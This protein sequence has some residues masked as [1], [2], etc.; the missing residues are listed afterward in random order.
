VNKDLGVILIDGGKDEESVEDYRKRVEFFII[1][2]Q[3]PFNDN[4]IKYINMENI[5]TLKYIWVESPI[6]GTIKAVAL[7]ESFGLTSQ[8]Q[9]DII[10]YTK[11]I[12]PAQMDI[13][14]ITVAL[15][16]VTDI[17]V[18]ISSLSPASDGLKTEVE[19]NIRYLYEVD[20]YEKGISASQ[21]EAVIYKTTNGAEQVD[22]FTLVSGSTVVTSGT[23]W[24]YTGTTFQ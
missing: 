23:F 7:N 21:L 10:Q 18:V 1:N 20:M 11:S 22:S 13:T 15:P 3:S 5:K 14:A 16:T 6:E 4:N 2:P 19:K 17:Q 24:K 12:A 9:T 8:E